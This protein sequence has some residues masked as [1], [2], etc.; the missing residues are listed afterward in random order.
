MASFFLLWGYGVCYKP[1]AWRI[2]ES[3]QNPH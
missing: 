3:D 2:K 1:V